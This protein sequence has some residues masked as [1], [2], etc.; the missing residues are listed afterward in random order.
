MLH[1]LVLLPLMSC[2]LADPLPDGKHYLVEHEDKHYLLQTKANEKGLNNT[3]AAD[4]QKD[5]EE[6]APSKRH[7]EVPDSHSG[8]GTALQG[9]QGQWSEWSSCSKTCGKNSFRTRTQQD[10]QKGFEFVPDLGDADKYSRDPVDSNEYE[11]IPDVVDVVDGPGEARL[12]DLSQQIQATKA[13]IIGNLALLPE[14]VVEL[15]S[16]LPEEYR[17]KTGQEI[18]CTEFNTCNVPVCKAWTLGIKN[19]KFRFGR[20]KERV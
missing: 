11:D 16:L 5:N 7:N 2:S 19:A 6:V 15:L 8:I 10:C 9:L 20:N 4:K 17:K 18:A 14:Y 1:L 13:K 12:D 3:E